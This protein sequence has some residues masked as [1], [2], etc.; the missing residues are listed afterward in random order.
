MNGWDFE[1]RVEGEIADVPGCFCNEVK[2]NLLKLLEHFYIRY[3]GLA[4]KLN[5]IFDLRRYMELEV[6]TFFLSFYIS[7]P[8]KFVIKMDFKIT[9]CFFRGNHVII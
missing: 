1:V 9:S 6:K 7:G 3:F 4:P 2:A 5:T 8:S